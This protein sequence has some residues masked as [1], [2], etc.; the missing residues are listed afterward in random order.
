MKIFVPFC[1]TIVGFD[2]IKSFFMFTLGRLCG[3][4]ICYLLIEGFLFFLYIRGYSDE[5]ISLF[6]IIKSLISIFID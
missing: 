2:D 6:S 4:A 1:G 3:L 5:Y